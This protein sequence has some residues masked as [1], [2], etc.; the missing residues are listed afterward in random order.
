VPEVY[1]LYKS[2]SRVK[3]PSTLHIT[4]RSI[5]APRQFIPGIGSSY[6]VSNMTSDKTN[7]ADDL[8]GGGNKSSN[9][10]TTDDEA[11]AAS[12]KR[13]KELK[14]KTVMWS[15]IAGLPCR[16]PN[17][18][19]LKL[20]TTKQ[21]CYSVQ[22]SATGSFVSMACVDD[23]NLYPIFIYDIPYGNFVMKF[24][25]HFGLVYEMSWSNLDKYLVT[26]SN[27]TTAR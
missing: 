19:S 27:D 8:L 20:S 1:S 16:I 23:D 11:A 15:R 24:L 4:L 26:A 9:E 2:G 7:P 13:D 25:G 5:L 18:L 22:F 10:K 3:Y 21:G 17:E 6:H 12:D 14:Q